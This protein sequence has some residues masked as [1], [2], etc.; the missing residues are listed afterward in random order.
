MTDGGMHGDFGV[1][2]GVY[3]CVRRTLFGCMLQPAAVVW[4]AANRRD[5]HVFCC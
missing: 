2:V 4:S 5:W 1:Y 3:V